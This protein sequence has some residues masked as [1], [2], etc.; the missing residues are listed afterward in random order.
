MSRPRKNKKFIDPR[1]FMDEKTE[2]IEE[3]FMSKLRGTAR[4]FGMAGGENATTVLDSIKFGAGAAQALA[5]RSAEGG[6]EAA[7][8][9]K[10]LN[11]V[12]V[13]KMISSVIKTTQKA[14]GALE[15]MLDKVPP[16]VQ[17]VVNAFEAAKQGW[18]IGSIDP[19]AAQA[20]AKVR[21]MADAA[22][23]AY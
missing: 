21:Q 15:A 6:N 22:L 4:G 20:F 12:Q 13:E 16:D 14:E 7:A 18:K 2:V 19:Q 10:V 5:G 23:D 17:K 1:Y 3:G 11:D 9:G 8:A